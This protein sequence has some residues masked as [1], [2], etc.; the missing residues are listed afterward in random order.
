MQ[1][2]SF[3]TVCYLTGLIHRKSC[4]QGNM[5]GLILE[6]QLKKTHDTAAP[7]SQNSMSDG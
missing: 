4:L 3:V 6:V 2:V 1:R 7:F 5:G